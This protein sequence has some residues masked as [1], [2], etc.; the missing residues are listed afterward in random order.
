MRVRIRRFSKLSRTFRLH[1]LLNLESSAQRLI[2]WRSGATREFEALLFTLTVRAFLTRVSNTPSAD[3]CYAV[4]TPHDALSHQSVAHSRSPAISSTA[5]PARP[6]DLPPA[7]LMDMGFAISRSFARR[8]RPHIRFLS[9]GP[10]VL[11]HA[12]FRPHLAVT[13]LRFATLHLHQVG[14]DFHLQAV[15]H[16]RRTAKKGGA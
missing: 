7:P 16:A 6:P 12:S 9:I 1:R 2:G 3:F 5:F 14:E 11:L 13:P 15:E 8:R 4:R 10:C